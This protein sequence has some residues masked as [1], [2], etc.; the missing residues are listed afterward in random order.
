MTEETELY[1]ARSSSFAPAANVTTAS[2]E[3]SET[4]LSLWGIGSRVTL[5]ISVVRY[6]YCILVRKKT[7]SLRR[8]GGKFGYSDE[9]CACGSAALTTLRSAVSR[10]FIAGV[11][12]RR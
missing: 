12:S 10:A 2:N 5:T 9:I 8:D 6:R 4:T 3:M 1:S 7:F 11:L